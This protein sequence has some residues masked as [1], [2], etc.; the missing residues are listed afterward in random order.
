MDSIDL[1]RSAP[2]IAFGGA[3]FLVVRWLRRPTALGGLSV[4]PEGHWLFGKKTLLKSSSYP[5]YKLKRP[6]QESDGAE[7]T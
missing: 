2:W 6:P 7:R 1:P 5:I 3:V 4:V